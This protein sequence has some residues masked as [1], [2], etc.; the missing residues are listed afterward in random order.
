MPL[1]AKALEMRSA[2][3]GIELALNG[4]EESL[5]S[6]ADRWDG[7]RDDVKIVIPMTVG[8]VRQLLSAYDE[9]NRIINSPEY[10]P[11]RLSE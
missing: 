11:A 9:L 10:A 1:E 2:I 5:G 6:I 8:T 4:F 3:D 7:A